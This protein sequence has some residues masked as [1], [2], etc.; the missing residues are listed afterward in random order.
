MMPGVFGPILFLLVHGSP[1]YGWRRAPAFLARAYPMVFA[2]EA[3]AVATGVPRRLP[4][5]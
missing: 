3:P 5:P 2:F 4:H 1:S